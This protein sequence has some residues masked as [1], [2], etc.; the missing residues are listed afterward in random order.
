MQLVSYIQSASNGFDQLS[1]RVY[2]GE[3]KRLFEYYAPGWDARRVRNWEGLRY[4]YRASLCP[5]PDL[6]VTSEVRIENDPNGHYMQDIR[7]RYIKRFNGN[8]YIY[9]PYHEIALLGV[10]SHD[11]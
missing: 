3:T 9:A 4:D 6:L 5:P 2:C 11:L 1:T 7:L 8:R 10:D